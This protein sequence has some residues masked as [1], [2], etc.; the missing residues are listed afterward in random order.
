MYRLSTDGRSDSTID[1]D[2]VDMEPSWL[3]VVFGFTF[4][5]ICIRGWFW[6]SVWV[7]LLAS[8][9]VWLHTYTYCYFIAG[10]FRYSNSMP[11]GIWLFVPSLLSPV[12]TC[13][14]DCLSVCLCAGSK[15]AQFGWRLKRNARGMLE[16]NFNARVLHSHIACRH[17]RKVF[18]YAELCAK[19][20]FNAAPSYA[21]PF[22]CHRVV[23]CFYRHPRRRHHHHLEQTRRR[24]TLHVCK[25]CLNVDLCVFVCIIAPRPLP[26]LPS[27]MT[28]SN[29]KP[30]C[31][32]P[33][34]SLA[35]AGR[36]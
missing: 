29:L 7:R 11:R 10:I 12:T 35:I 33:P 27:T 2:W 22:H 9:L 31:A 3:V 30:P 14:Y 32:V 28:P 16:W 17:D 20:L 23:G 6:V 24:R 5:M 18:V 25:H 34:E 36:L 15:E 26:P 4:R 19:Y 8:M 13:M 1:W 21:L